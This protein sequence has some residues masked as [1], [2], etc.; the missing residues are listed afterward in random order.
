MADSSRLFA[1]L[2]EGN[3]PAIAQHFCAHEPDCASSRPSAHRALF[4]TILKPDVR[5]QQTLERMY[6]QFHAE[7][8]TLAAAACV[9]SAI[10]G[11]C[12]TGTDLN[13]LAP[14]CA[15]IPVLLDNKGVPPLAAAYLLQ[16]QAWVEIYT[17]DSLE[18]VEQTFLRQRHAAEQAASASLQILNSAL[19]A[20]SL[21][22]SGE[23]ARAELLLNDVAPL[24]AAGDVSP[25]AAAHYQISCGMISF[26]VG[27]PR[28]GIA[29]LTALLE[30]PAF[31]GVPATLEALALNHLLHAYILAGDFDGSETIAERIR[32]LAIPAGNN[33]HR[34]YLHLSLAAAALAAGR[35]Q[36]ALYHSEEA[37]SRA[38][39]SNAG[40]AIRINALLYGLCLADLGRDREALDHLESWIER[41]KK[42]GYLMIAQ[43]GI[44]E[45][46]MLY[47][48]Q[49]NIERARIAWEQ[50]H[51][52]LPP[53]E[54]VLH[55]YRPDDWYRDLECR[56]FPADSGTVP[57]AVSDENAVPVQIQTLGSFRMIVNGRELFDRD[58]RGRNSK[59][60]LFVLIANGGYKVSR[61][62]LAGIMWPDADG[63]LAANS[64]NVT[65]SRLRRVGKD[66]RTCPMQWVVSKHMTVS[67][68]AGLCRVDAL[69]FREEMRQA[70]KSP[71][72]SAGLAQAL[73]GYTGTFLP[74]EDCC[75]CIEAFRTDLQRLYLSGVRSLVQWYQEHG[76]L[77][78]AMNLLEQAVG[79]IPLAEELYEQLM[80]LCLLEGKPVQAVEIFHRA[81]KYFADELGIRP[82]SRLTTIAHEARTRA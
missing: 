56:L 68:S 15:R 67:L 28:E 54:P 32:N 37:I 39:R 44:F 57:R 25:L 63:D 27:R 81:A 8:D 2:F 70:L 41:W 79:F 42:A 38:N 6:R 24:L 16:Q 35:P 45:T 76:D 48:R 40:M 65:L 51:H 46:A 18:P 75:G 10:A 74:A 61:D 23:F 78:Q 69:S 53:G 55:L 58:W 43:Q 20:Y 64:L 29:T 59:R 80:R 7:G 11:I 26:L 47:L 17:A 36:K 9:G 82:G 3:H 77:E 12:D 22:Y 52:L 30:S 13:Q 19:S 71:A 72:E 1:F 21:S 60:L 50:A 33:F 34:S 31:H 66:G 62:R 73:Q 5:F 49:G 14:W 4:Q